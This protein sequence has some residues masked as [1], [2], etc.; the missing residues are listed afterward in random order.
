MGCSGSKAKN[1]KSSSSN[2][3]SND[4]EALRDR[5]VEMLKL[6]QMELANSQKVTFSKILMKASTLNATYRRINDVYHSLDANGDGHLDDDDAGDEH[7]LAS[8]G[9]GGG[10][11]LFF[12]A[13][14][15]ATTSHHEQ[16]VPALDEARDDGIVRQVPREREH[17]R[18][19]VA[20]RD[21]HRLEGRRAQHAEQ[22]L[23]ADVRAHGA[24]GVGRRHDARVPVERIFWVS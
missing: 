15:S 22:R 23:G 16:K 10:G 7:G 2:N 12:I 1:G 19:A 5:I 3:L 8:R 17:G 9:G 20:A 6:K 14:S 13:S 18:V 4:A 24:H 21:E 11:G